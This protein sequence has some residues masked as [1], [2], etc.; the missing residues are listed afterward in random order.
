MRGVKDK[1]FEK[2]GGFWEFP[3]SA[4]EEVYKILDEVCESVEIVNSGRITIKKGNSNRFKP[5]FDQEIKKT[6]IL[7]HFNNFDIK[8]EIHTVLNQHLNKKL[9]FKN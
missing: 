7:K 9:T 8:R 1:K 4:F 5:A 2:I 3:F 6:N